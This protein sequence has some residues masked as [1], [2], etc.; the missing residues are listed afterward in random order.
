MTRVYAIQSVSPD[1]TDLI[2]VSHL[3]KY[4]MPS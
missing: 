2:S 1:Y 4:N 3:Y